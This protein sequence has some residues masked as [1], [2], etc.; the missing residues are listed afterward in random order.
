[1][2]E[3]L[4]AGLGWPVAGAMTAISFAASFI[5]AAFGI[6]GGTIMLAAL[7]SFLP[8]PAIIP[9][10]GLVQLGSNG[11]RAAMFWRHF[12]PGLLLPF[13]IGTV[14]GVGVG[15]SVVV[16]LSPGTIKL[17]LGLFILWSVFS[18]PPAFLRRSA[19]L[20]GVVSSFLTMFFGGT[21]PFIAAFVKS[22]GYP[23]QVHVSAQAV[24]MTVQ[25]ALKTLVFGGL[26]FAFS[27]WLGFTAMLIGAGLVGTYAGKA[28]L[29]RMNDKGFRRVLNV[30]LC[31]VALRLIWDGLRSFS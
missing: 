25:H 29:L 28:A 1:M 2:T 8:A 14:I 11:G 30:L 12:P 22:R 13:A 31:L 15:G 18:K 20:V 26:G 4:H 5:T 3:L 23:R 19:W 24:L 27:Q 16:T 7:A 10:H 6:G 9:V 21:G 17:G